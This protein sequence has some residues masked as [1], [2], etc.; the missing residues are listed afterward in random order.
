M[1]FSLAK[2]LFPLCPCLA[3]MISCGKKVEE[4]KAAERLRPPATLPEAIELQASANGSFIKDPSELEIPR[5]A[6]IK[7]PVSV[8]A[9][10]PT[11]N[12]KLRLEVNVLDGDEEFHCYWQGDGDSYEFK[13]CHDIDGQDLGFTKTNLPNFTF[14][15]DQGKS[16]ALELEAAPVGQ[17]TKAVLKLPTVWK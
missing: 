14:P 2:K 16:L 3:L 15:I 7:I 6:D 8:P 1:I 13:S 10:G 9:S 5:D 12:F 4:G 11:G 17:T